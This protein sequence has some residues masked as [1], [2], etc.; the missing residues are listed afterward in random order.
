MYLNLST[1]FSPFQNQESQILDFDALTFSG[2][3]PHIKIHARGPIKEAVMISQRV[4]NFEDFGLTLMAVDALKR[5]EVPAIQLF[6]PYFP[7]ARQDRVMVAGEALSVKVYA[8]ILNSLQLN[9]VI[10]FDPHSEVAPA[11]INNCKSIDNSA[12]VKTCLDQIEEDVLLISPDAGAL[13]KAYK[14]AVKL[15]GKEV[16]ECSKKRDTRTG[17]LSDFMVYADD[18][19]GKA[20]LIVDDICDGG[21]TFLGLADKLREKNAGNLYLAVSH[22][23]FSKGLSELKRKFSKVFTTNSIR[24]YQEGPFLQQINLN[25]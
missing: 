13:K 11:L 15:G 9:R 3:E 5:L 21:G 22:G 19:Q 24:D 7:G 17:H 25:F 12:F 6:L 14:L 16:I 10:I 8:D 2:G 4:N 18:L 1:N 23:I 20:C